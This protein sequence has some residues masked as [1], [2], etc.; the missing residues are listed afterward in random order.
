MCCH[1]YTLFKVALAFGAVPLCGHGALV[2][3]AKAVAAHRLDSSVPRRKKVNRADATPDFV[4]EGFRTLTHRFMHAAS[5][6][7]VGST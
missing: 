6:C 2:D 1:L 3:V 5:W 7:T 4:A